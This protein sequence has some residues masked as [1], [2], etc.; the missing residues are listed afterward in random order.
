MAV[1]RYC[2]RPTMTAVVSGHIE[3]TPFWSQ[4]PVRAAVSALRYVPRI[5]AARLESVFSG[6]DEV[7]IPML[8]STRARAL[9][10]G[11]AYVISLIAAHMRPRR[12]FEIGTA[13]GQG[14][15]L[16]GAPGG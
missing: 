1:A 10:H 16:H 7:E 12:I 8:H 5:P 11:E 2:G 4:F 14:T 3:V 13:S 15:A 6:I 9:N